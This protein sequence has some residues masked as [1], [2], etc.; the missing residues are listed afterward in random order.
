MAISPFELNT[1]ITR[2][3]DFSILKQNE[4]SRGLVD[5]QNF[6]VNL[7]KENTKK[8]QQ[9]QKSEDTQGKNTEYNASDK[10]NGKYMGDGGKNRKGAA[11]ASD[12]TV[13]VKGTSRLDIKI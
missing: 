11:K 6:H 8:L 9:V 2:A 12:G 1:G 7:E 5:H 13:V 4:D 10:G 3:Q